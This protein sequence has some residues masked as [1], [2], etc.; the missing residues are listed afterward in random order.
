MR[1]IKK[2]MLILMIVF[3][4]FGIASVGLHGYT[5]AELEKSFK[6]DEKAYPYEQAVIEQDVDL[7]EIL[8]LL[9]KA[10]A[11][12]DYNWSDTITAPVS[13]SYY[14]DIH[15]RTPVY[16]VE[17]GETIYCKPFEINTI[18]RGIES[19]PTDVRGWRLGRP[20]AVEGKPL[21][22]ELLYV[23]H[24]DLQKVARAWMEEN[25][26]MDWMRQSAKDILPKGKLPTK[27]EAV[28]A[29]TLSVDRIL[30]TEG[31]YISPDL[32]SPIFSGFTYTMFAL[33][34]AAG[35]AYIV[36]GKFVIKKQ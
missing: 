11:A 7:E 35:I 12:M 10:T 36:L 34:A 5:N 17:Q 25:D 1:T 15:D 23:K 3:L 21:N 18:C 20:F 8:K 14:K 26:I 2:L 16:T 9:P 28:N 33:A 32:K 13:I 4:L 24:S 22:E 31:V 6:P 29:Y 30:Y 27:Q 19:L